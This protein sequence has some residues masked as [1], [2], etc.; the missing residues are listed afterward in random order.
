MRGEGEGH[1]GGSSSR[2]GS[3]RHGDRDERQR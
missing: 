3:D 2:H 1:R